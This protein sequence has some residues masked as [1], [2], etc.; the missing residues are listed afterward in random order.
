MKFS[1][2]FFEFEFRPFEGRNSSSNEPWPDVLGV[3][4]VFL[5]TGMF[6]L[7]LEVKTEIGKEG[8][9]EEEIT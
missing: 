6:M 5:V 3:T 4:V 2:L 7:G 1:F 8:E 9:E